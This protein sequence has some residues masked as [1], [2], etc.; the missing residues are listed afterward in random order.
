MLVEQQ[1]RKAA[2]EAQR[3][4]AAR[5]QKRL[6][7]LGKLVKLKKHEVEATRKAEQARLAEEGS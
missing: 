1:R 5:R 7:V 2:L 4:E 6:A 3:I